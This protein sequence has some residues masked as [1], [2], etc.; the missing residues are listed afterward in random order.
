MRARKGDKTVAG[1]EVAVRDGFP[2]PRKCRVGV[3]AH[4]CSCDGKGEHLI[5]HLRRGGWRIPLVFSPEHGMWSTHQDME[6]VDG[7]AHDPVFGLPVRSL[8][9]R[10]EES[11]TPG[12]Q[13]MAAIDMLV[14]DLQDVG[15]R[16]YTYAATMIRAMRAAAATGRKVLVLDRPNP[17]NGVDVEGGDIEPGLR[18]FVGELSVPQRHGMTIGEL[19]LLARDSLHIDVDLQVIPV[20]GWDRSSY[21]DELDRLWIP[22]SPNMPT[23]E[24]AVVYPG[25]CLLEGT[26][27]SEGRGTTTPFLVLG[28]PF[29]RAWELAERIQQEEACG[30]Y[31]V[32]PTAF[33][34]QFGKF[35]GK[36]CKG[37]RVHVSDRRKFRPLAFGLAVV[38]WLYLLHPTT[39]L[40][41]R[42]QYEFV[43]DVPA[44]DLLLGASR[45]REAIEKGERVAG[46]IDAMTESRDRPAAGPV[47]GKGEKKG[48]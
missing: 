34:P 7:R 35:A 8:Y 42:E 14:V 36:V 43:S 18:S 23:V 31:I 13:D 11:L 21:Y 16:Y 44:I 46:I 25:M 2:L 39:F 17:I 3:L 26:N 10:D 37:V 20:E 1:L 38:K 12:I 15:A 33:R 19:A 40:W 22:P 29:V 45:Y 4:Q 27:I 6:A 28:A 32:T 47:G 48:T 5:T 9:G 24:T 41:R 30:G